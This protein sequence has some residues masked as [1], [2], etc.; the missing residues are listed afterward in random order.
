MESNTPSASV[1][2]TPS[3]S[4]SGSESPSQTSSP[5]FLNQTILLKPSSNEVPININTIIFVVV[6]GVPLIILLLYCIIRKLIKK[7]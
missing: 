3:P 6:L 2:D 4:Q 7:L 5:S 1:T